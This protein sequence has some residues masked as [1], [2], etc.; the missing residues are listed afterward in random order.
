LEKQTGKHSQRAHLNNNKK[1]SR[2]KFTIHG[3]KDTPCTPILASITCDSI[4]QIEYL[5]AGFEG[6]VGTELIKY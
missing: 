2:R 6:L 3:K 5:G 4:A 1:C